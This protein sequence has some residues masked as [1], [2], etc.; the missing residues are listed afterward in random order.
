MKVFLTGGTG[1]LGGRVARALLDAGHRVTA[2]VRDP[3]R[4]VSLVGAGAELA[5]GELGVPGDWTDALESC[6]GVI[7]TAAKV[8]N[9]S[10]DPEEFD[11]VNLYGTL[12]LLDRVRAARID[13]VVVTGSLFALGPSA[14][15]P[16]DETAVDEPP[17]PLAGANDYV[18]TK[19]LLARRIRERQRRGGRIMLAFPTVLLGPGPLTAGNHTARVLDQ[20]GRRRFPGLVGSGNQVWNLVPV[21][22]AARGHVQILERGRPGEPYI[23]GGEDW[24]QRR[25]VEAAAA[26]FGVRPPLRRLGTRLPLAV[27]AACEL[28]AAVTGRPPYLTRGEVRLYDADWAF[29]SVKARRELDY[30]PGG[31]EEALD[32]TVGWIRD[33]VWERR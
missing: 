29:S 7:H 3:A 32:A 19:T 24:T 30:D 23:L 13:R 33:T 4:A 12:D 9:W 5:E 18:R 6:E 27:G 20:V 22:G 8:E 21:E 15:A 16:L 17:G 28:W 11:R 26:R 10:V 31:V 25:L 14:G 2:L 1:Y